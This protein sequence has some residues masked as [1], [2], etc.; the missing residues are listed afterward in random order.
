[1]LNDVY[2]AAVNGSRTTL[3]QLDLS[4]A[5]DTLD[6]STIYYD[7]F[8]LLRLISGPAL[9]WASSYLVCRSQS[10]RVG[11]KQSSSIVCEYG[12]PQWSVLGPLLF[13]LYISPLAKVISSFG[14]NH[15]QFADDMQLY[16]ALKDD[17]STQGYQNAFVQFNIGSI[18]MVCRWTQTRLA[19]VYTS[20]WK[21]MASW[22]NTVDFGCV[23]ISPASSGW[24]LRFTIDD[25]LSFDEHVGLDNVCKSYNFHIRALRHIFRHISDDE[26]MTIAWSMV[27]GRLDYCNS[28]LHRMLSSNINKLQKGT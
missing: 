25:T 3:Q 24:S 23:S 10:V 5:F 7:D 20:A 27:N 12:F 1:M 21:R 22:V 4:S 14:V 18:S 9:H 8:V 17:N 28:V 16:I 13:T 26:A 11:Q 2:C 15:E 6:M 19:L